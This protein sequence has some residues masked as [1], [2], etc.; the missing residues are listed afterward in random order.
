LDKLLLHKVSEHGVIKLV[1]KLLKNGVNVNAVWQKLT[2]LIQAC[3]NGHCNVMKILLE[4]RAN[5]NAGVK[6]ALHFAAKEG[7]LDVARILLENKSNVNAK[8]D[9][10]NTPLHEAASY[11]NLEL[12]KLL[13][14]NGAEIES[15]E[16]GGETPLYTACKRGHLPIVEYLVSKKADVETRNKSQLTLLHAA[17]NNRASISTNF[18]DVAS[19]LLENDKINVNAQDDKGNTPLH[20]STNKGNIQMNELLVAKGADTDLKN[21]KGKTPF[22]RTQSQSP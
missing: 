7:R 15:K 19:Y 14:A 5:V 3:T 8:D 6:T 20:V 22:L 1:E 10:R 21:C 4:Y 2:P 11:G 13:V 18:V 17:A 12:A 16:K 9:Y